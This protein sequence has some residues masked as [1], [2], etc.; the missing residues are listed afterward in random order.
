MIM[1]FIEF[2]KILIA[3]FDD[4]LQENNPYFQKRHE[5]VLARTSTYSN[6]SQGIARFA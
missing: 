3:K 1:Y 2:F 4:Y 5:P 6:S